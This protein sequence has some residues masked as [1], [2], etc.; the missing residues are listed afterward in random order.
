MFS[1]GLIV[2]FGLLLLLGVIAH[3]RDGF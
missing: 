1:A 3:R 2:I